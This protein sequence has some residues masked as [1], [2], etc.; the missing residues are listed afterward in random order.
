MGLG[1]WNKVKEFGKKLWGGVSSVWNNIVRPMAN[2][3]IGT[4]IQTATGIPVSTIANGVGTGI[5]MVNSFRGINMNNAS[6]KINNAFGRGR[7]MY[8]Q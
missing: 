2:G 6:Q 4:A 1:F 7:Q 8:N 5:D 3:P